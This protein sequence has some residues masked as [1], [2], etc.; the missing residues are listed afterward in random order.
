MFSLSSDGCGGDG[1]DGGDGGS[2]D[3]GSGEEPR[4]QAGRWWESLTS[5]GVEW[6]QDL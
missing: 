5:V 6:S 2:G 1:G 4:N 3:G